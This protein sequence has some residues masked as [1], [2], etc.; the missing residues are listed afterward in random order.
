MNT[1]TFSLPQD[2]YTNLNAYAPDWVP[3]QGFPVGHELIGGRDFW[4]Y[5]VIHLVADMKFITMFSMLFGAGILLQSERAAA[6]GISPARIHYG[7]MVVL[8]G[9]GLLHAYFIWYGDILTDY[10]M[11]GMLL[12]P[13]RKARPGLL[14]AL[15][16]VMI[17]TVSVINFCYYENLH[18]APL[19]QL[20]NWNDNLLADRGGNDYELAAYRGTYHDAFEHRVVASFSGQTMEFVTWS[21]W[22]CGGA[23]LIGMALLKRKFFHGAWPREVYATIAILAIPIGWAVT[24]LGI[25]FNEA[26]GWDEAPASVFSVWGLGGEFNYWGSLITELG[27]LSLGVLVAVWAAQSG[28]KFFRQ[29]L[30]PVRAIGKMAL[31]NYIAQSLIATT[32]FYG[33]GFGLFGYLGHFELLFVVF[34]VWILQLLISPI[35]MSYFR[36]GPLEWVWHRIVYWRGEPPPLT[37]AAEPLSS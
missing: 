34:P 29:C 35:Y 4:T 12:F 18:V 11:C 1:W 25:V 31:S 5:V 19:E 23:M 14:L 36:Q 26:I 37:D 30:W 15:G 27:Y 6:R 21:F 22:R 8:L 32:L 3:G 16:L 33:Y 2:A 10:A 17:G 28:R 9:F 20:Q 7:R 13:L 24:G